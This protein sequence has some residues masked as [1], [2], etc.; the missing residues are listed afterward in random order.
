MLATELQTFS[1][2][3]RKSNQYCTNML[4]KLL[5]ES[6]QV[7][8]Q[9]SRDWILKSH[10]NLSAPGSWCCLSDSAGKY[11]MPT[12][13]PTWLIT[14]QNKAICHYCHLKTV[15]CHLLRLVI[16]HQKF[17]PNSIGSML[18]NQINQTKSIWKAAGIC[19]IIAFASPL[20]TQSTISYCFGWLESLVLKLTFVKESKD[21]RSLCHWNSNSTE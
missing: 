5:D 17:L 12:R 2:S 14:C 8:K 4:L 16:T 20:L 18:Y 10:S 19:R 21:A 3:Q 1:P 13:S 7:T 6:F 9:F 11:F 15:T